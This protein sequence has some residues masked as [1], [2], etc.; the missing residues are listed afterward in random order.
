MTLDNRLRLA[1]YTRML[2]EIGYGLP[3]NHDLV[4]VELS[5]V[6]RREVQDLGRSS[7]GDEHTAYEPETK[8]RIPPDRSPSPP[9]IA[10]LRRNPR[11]LCFR[12]LFPYQGLSLT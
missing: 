5:G 12:G 10:E 6:K 9:P 4:E 3:M 11:D 2:A 8:E 1:S 7:H